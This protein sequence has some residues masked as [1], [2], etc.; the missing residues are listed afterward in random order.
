MALATS[1]VE[2]ERAE[3]TEYIT[4]LR[5]KLADV[6]RQA[7]ALLDGSDARDAK[8]QRLQADMDA[9]DAKIAEQSECIKKMGESPYVAEQLSRAV[10]KC[11]RLERD[12]EEQKRSLEMAD[13][14]YREQLRSLRRQH[15]GT[16]DNLRAQQQKEVA[17]LVERRGGSATDKLRSALKAE[18]STVKRQVKEIAGLQADLA[19]ALAQAG[20]AGKD[21]QAGNA[22]NSTINMLRNQIQGLQ[23]GLAAT[24]SLQKS[25]SDANATIAT[26]AQTIARIEPSLTAANA[27]AAEHKREVSELERAL[28]TERNSVTTLKEE[29]NAQIRPNQPLA[30]KCRHLSA[31]S[32]VTADKERKAEKAAQAELKSRQYEID[33]LRE[34]LEVATAARIKATEKQNLALAAKDATIRTQ[35][36]RIGEVQGELSKLQTQLFDRAQVGHYDSLL[37]DATAAVAKAKEEAER[38]KEEAERAK[39][40]A[41]QANVAQQQAKDAQHQAKRALKEQAGELLWY[42]QKFLDYQDRLLMHNG[43]RMNEA[44][45]NQM[46]RDLAKDNGLTYSVEK[47]GRRLFYMDK[48]RRQYLRTVGEDGEAVYDVKPDIDALEAS[49]SRPVEKYDYESEESQ[50]PF[51]ELDN[52]PDHFFTP[53]TQP[54]GEEALDVMKAMDVMDTMDADELEHDYL[55]EDD[56]D[57]ERD[58][59]GTPAAESAAPATV[60]YTPLAFP[61]L[62]FSQ[63]SALPSAAALSGTMS[64]HAIKSQKLRALAAKQA[65]ARAELARASEP[66]PKPLLDPPSPRPTK[67]RA[68]KGGEKKKQPSSSSQAKKAP[69]KRPAKVPAA[70]AKAAPPQKATAKKVKAAK[71]AAAAASGSG[72]TAASLQAP[73]PPASATQF[74]GPGK[75]AG[76]AVAV[77]TPGPALEP[78]LPQLQAP[79]DTFTPGLAP[80]SVPSPA[81]G[82]VPG[83][84][85]KRGRAMRYDEDDRIDPLTNKRRKNWVGYGLE[86]EVNA[87]PTHLDTAPELSGTV[88]TE[89]G[90]NMVRRS[91]RRLGLAGTGNSLSAP[92]PTSTTHSVFS[93]SP[94]AVVSA[95]SPLKY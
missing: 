44:T 54:D 68:T 5:Q 74:T 39:E 14:A 41:A 59:S 69:P 53:N 7:R 4:E 15:E 34:D 24:A 18:S 76:D 51:H 46:W 84:P 16:V 29:N 66:S 83:L 88:E 21:E 93:P 60:P 94:L 48:N 82:T 10:D 11:A 64:P 31:A 72:P 90:G 87:E 70:K 42:K 25:L 17:E 28:Q 9:R 19:V 50:V 55:V 63:S 91:V 26:H 95:P 86:P 13:K 61:R 78:E 2:R 58:S 36:R 32:D 8:I 52:D 45:R 73:A 47:Q 49:T 85:K 57:R 3:A 30:A 77:A 6:D 56:S 92:S 38:A 20:G 71:A 27:A 75:E 89:E 35:A 62:M 67:K 40:E 37:V 33:G 65:A 80:D 1:M 22:A 43:H 79:A 12:V 81:A 23:R